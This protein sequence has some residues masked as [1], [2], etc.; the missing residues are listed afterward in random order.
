MPILQT[1]NLYVLGNYGL[2]K[3]ALQQLIK[4]LSRDVDTVGEILLNK[5]MADFPCITRGEKN[6]VGCLNYQ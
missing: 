6:L 1:E 2:L 5:K 3:M 4:A